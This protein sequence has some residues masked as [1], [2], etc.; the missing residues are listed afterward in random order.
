LF[1]NLN[2][3]GTMATLAD[4]GV[5]AM[6]EAL[7]VEGTS[8]LFPS[9]DIK[10]NP[11]D[12]YLTCLAETLVQLTNCDPQVALD[13]IQWPNDIWDLVVVLPRLRIQDGDSKDPAAELKQ[14]VCG[15]CHHS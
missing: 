13:S 4:D 12:I 14:R 6:L 15:H 11:M 8:P 2:A 10:N 7:K 3:A 1:P 9:A 5:S